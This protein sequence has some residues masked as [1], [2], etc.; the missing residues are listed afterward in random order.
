MQNMQTLRYTATNTIQSKSTK[1]TNNTIMV[2]SANSNPGIT[3]GDPTSEFSIEKMLG[4]GSF[5]QV[6]RA[7]HLRTGAIVAVKVVPNQEGDAAE[8]DKIMG[9]IDILS[10]CNS[11]FIVGYFEC[12]VAPPKKRMEAGEMWIVMEFCDG[13]SI[14][15]LIEAAGGRGSFAMP[16]EAIRAACAGIV[17][18]LEYLHK[19]EICHRDIKCGNVL[20]TNDGHVKLADFGVSAELTNTINKRKTVVGSPFWIAPEVIKE[21]HYDGRADVWSLGITAIEMAEGAPPHSNLNP[22][23]AIF[24]IPSK[25]APTL[26]DPDNWSPEMLDFIRCCCKKDPSERSDSALLTSHPFVK[27][28]V[29]ALQRMHANFDYSGNGGLRGYEQEATQNTNRPLGLPALRSFMDRMRNPLDAV[30]KERDMGHPVVG[31]GGGGFDEN[32]ESAMASPLSTKDS[33]GGS[34]FDESDDNNFNKKGVATSNATI[35]QRNLNPPD[36]NN[37]AIP[38]NNSGGGQNGSGIFNRTINEIDP[39]LKN[40]ALFQ[41]E[42]YK[43]NQLYEAKL[44]SL[45]AAHE[46]SRRKIMISAMV[47]NRKAVDVHVL[48]EQAA[49]RRDIELKSNAVYNDAANNECFK[50]MLESMG[51]A[52]AA[53]DSGGNVERNANFAVPRMTPSP[54]L[55]YAESDEVVAQSLNDLDNQVMY[56]GRPSSDESEDDINLDHVSIGV[57][58]TA[59]NERQ[60]MIF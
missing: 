31:Q 29:N 43:L 36:W 18:G 53:A 48:M 22:L 46:E 16:E 59:S 60:E 6:F 27:Q 51:A 10:K 5:G 49:A 9:E 12:F 23:R 24:L 26:A 13:G 54:P 21:A 8:A 41:E 30:K 44:A 28:E 33:E 47:R 32:D 3:A 35:E 34:S 15:D 4:E 37:M 52:A 25:P 38:N 2:V 14:S 50:V 40:D 58:P 1:Q 11:P 17:L 55:N 19:K 7:T 56:H 20:L 57:S 39:E 45:Q 42:M